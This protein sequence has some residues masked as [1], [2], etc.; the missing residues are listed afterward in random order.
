M[1][2]AHLVRLPDWPTRL[3]QAC[4]AARDRPLHWG[5]CDCVT[6]AAD[7]VLAITGIDPLADLRGLWRSAGGAHRLLSRLGGLEAAV[8]WRIGA[9][10][11][12]PGLA[13]R[14]DVVLVLAPAGP[15]LTVCVGDRLLGPGVAGQQ[16]WPLHAA[17]PTVRPVAAWG[18]GHA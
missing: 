12:G 14:G 3:A 7:I 10:L 16:Q 8:R 4:E 15:A 5:R 9:P 1:L 11:A 2:A 6:F 17:H 13:W 18:I